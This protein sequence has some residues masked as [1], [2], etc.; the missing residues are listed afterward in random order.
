MKIKTFFRGI[1]GLFLITTVLSCKKEESE[2]V[3][4][5]ENLEDI[6][7]DTHA[8]TTMDVYLPEGRTDT[9]RVIFLLHGGY[10]SAGD[11]DELTEQAKYYRGK[12]F[13]VVNMNYK[14]SGTDENNVH[15]TQM[16]DI[17]QAVN[18]VASKASEWHISKEKFGMGG[19]SAGAHLA[20]LYTYGYNTTNKIKAV[21]SLAGPTNFTDTRGIGA[22]QAAAVE[23]FLGAS[24]MD[25][26]ALYVQASPSSRVSSLSKPTL[27]IHGTNDIVVPVTQSEDLHVKLNGLNVTNKLIMYDSGHEVFT[28]TNTQEILDEIE[29]WF[30]LYIK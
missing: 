15:P 23:A 19:I 27:F 5:P 24:F 8:Q 17:H 13:A 3:L 1:V 10:W 25:N 6:A 29:K 14:L 9:T 21:V 11:K 12:G 2:K 28:T 16:N 7:Y 4:K 20:L 18:F 30:R 22:E 26:P